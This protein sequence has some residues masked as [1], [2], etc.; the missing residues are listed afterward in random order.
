[1]LG[2]TDVKHLCLSVAV[3]IL[4]A[5]IL[6]FIRGG[7][8]DAPYVV[9]VFAAAGFLITYGASNIIHAD[10]IRRFESSTASRIWLKPLRNL[11]AV[12]LVV[13]YLF[14]SGSVI[15]GAGFGGWLVAI[16]L[17]VILPLVTCLIAA[18]LP[19]AFGLMTATAICL[20]TIL[21]HPYFRQEPFAR[22]AWQRLLERDLT[23]W[24]VSWAILAALS[25]TSAIPIA[26]QRRRLTRR[27]S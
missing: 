25:L 10:W 14:W 11:L 3:G 19:I 17:G 16:A 5:I 23:M 18:H 6:T 22:E 12:A 26:I 27:C 2:G 20:S 8:S 9:P 24:S 21:H 13:G 15:Q 7:W 1:V 4:C